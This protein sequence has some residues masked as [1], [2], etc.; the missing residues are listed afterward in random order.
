M[1]FC[2]VRSKTNAAWCHWS[3]STSSTVAAIC[4]FHCV[5]LMSWTMARRPPEGSIWIANSLL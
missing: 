5:P 3:S 2:A 1:S 4:A